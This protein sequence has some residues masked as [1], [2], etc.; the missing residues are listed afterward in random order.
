MQSKRILLLACCALI[1]LTPVF[2]AKKPKP[3]ATPVA[4]QATPVVPAM[5]APQRALH[6]VNR[7]TW[8][9]QP[10]EVAEVSKIGVDVW[11]ERQLHPDTIAESPVLTEKLALL[12]TLTI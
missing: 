10:G 12:D 4:K 2:A 9:P 6:A 5:T 3:A 8:G 11:I 1:G 7:L